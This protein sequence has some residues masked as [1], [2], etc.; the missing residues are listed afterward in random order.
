MLNAAPVNREQARQE[1][2]RFLQ[3]R[4]G[5]QAAR[6]MRLVGTTKT[7]TEEA[8][9]Y[10][11]F[12]VGQEQGF[13]L[14]S[15]D[16]RT[17]P[18]LG[19]S[20]EGS[21]CEE[22]MPENLRAWL[23]GYGRQMKML[24]TVGDQ[25][26]A[27][28]RVRKASLL[29]TSI[30]PLLKTR[31]DQYAPYNDQC[32]YVNGT[33]GERTV[34]GCV[35]T[36]LAQLMYFYKQPA[37]TTADIPGYTTATLGRTISGV[38]QGTALD[39]G[40]MLETYTGS[41]TNEQA[42]A[43]ATLMKTI[44][45]AVQMNYNSYTQGGSSA[46][47][48]GAPSVLSTYFGYDV[49]AKMAYRNDYT[50]SGWLDLVYGELAKG[51]PVFYNG[52]SIAG[53][54]AFICDGYDEEDF[55]HINWGWGGQSDGYYRLSILKADAA[56]IGGSSYAYSFDQSVMV[57]VKP[58]DDGNNETN[59]NCLETVSIGVYKAPTTFNRASSGNDFYGIGVDIWFR[60]PL[61]SET[62]YDHGFALIKDGK[63][64]G[65]APFFVYGSTQI[66]QPGYSHNFGVNGLTMGAGLDDGVYRI[67]GVSRIH[68][69]SDWHVNGNSDT[70]YITA[71]IE[72]N[73][74]TLETMSTTTQ[75]NLSATLALNG[76]ARV[77][78]PATIVAT[79]TNNSET[80][81][82]GTLQLVRKSGGDNYR[83][84][85]TQ[86]DI[87]GNGTKEVTFTITPQAIGTMNLELWNKLNI[88]IGELSINV[89]AGDGATTGSLEIGT[90]TIKNGS[91]ASEPSEPGEVYGSYA[92]ATV[93]ITNTSATAHTSGLRVWL[94]KWVLN[95]AQTE[96]LG[97]G[98]S[99]KDVDLSLP[100]GGTGSVSFRL[101][102][103][104]PD[105]RYSF[106]Y[107]TTDGTGIDRSPFFYS[108][109]AITF[110][111]ADGTTSVL[112]RE[113]TTSLDVPAKAVAADLS[114]TSLATLT[115]NGNPNTLYFFGA[116]DAVPDVLNGKN[117]V[118]GSE[119]E[120]LTLSDGH[121]FYTPV[122]FTAKKA[123]YTRQFSV[124]AD[125][126]RGWSTIVVPFD[127]DEVKSSEKVIDWFHSS[128]DTGKN[129]WLKEFSSE[130]EGA[131]CFDFADELKA[132]TPYIIAVPGNKW[133]ESWNLTNR[134]IT[135]SGSNVSIA[136]DAK[137]NVNGNVFKFVGTTCAS[138]VT[139]AYMLNGDG[140][141]FVKT[142]G[143]HKQDAFRASF[144]AVSYVSSTVLPI[145]QEGSQATGLQHVGIGSATDDGTVYSLQGMRVNGLMR[146]LPK[147]IYVKNGKKIIR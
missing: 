42:T 79:V 106:Y 65:E 121:D 54:H 38:D 35:A 76:T 9:D 27:R 125:G 63:M 29:R 32:P 22:Q 146:H 129:F 119:A 26:E 147:G 100:A 52:Q 91:L 1:A 122:A 136:A 47:S 124:G 130:N 113:G 36:A 4:H 24:G 87:A 44:G 123:S 134:D 81:Y 96:W 133:G 70:H 141:A 115:P 137:A 73:T 82:T 80:I 92:D 89:E 55:F 15:G 145:V 83:A 56:G 128:S 16:D 51:N 71:T 85:G 109:P 114:G 3:A 78:S 48:D 126:S 88:K 98:V 75:A 66:A 93:S 127:V 8:R 41:Y 90:T 107:A 57:K 62:E 10:Y 72:G 60:T 68:G 18:V 139:D 102:N 95:D 86:T 143:K 67:V 135:F 140:T 101:D 99:Y 118:K 53:G 19:Y 84:D 12:N 105:I 23:E 20:D 13:V 58:T 110:Y 34:T 25:T 144:R 142:T 111:A 116:D 14:I 103:M 108:V 69:Q 39:W 120:T 31:W 5:E 77:G 50:Y 37:Q 7:N 112:K 59:L 131:V 11:V 94:F 64:V 45:T 117:V 49:D 30:S 2:M 74:L 138:D 40:N 104:L 46:S 97:S 21:F 17:D 33:D 61:A 43:V 6:G 28:S 132:Y